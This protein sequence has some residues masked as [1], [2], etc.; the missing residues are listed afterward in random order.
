MARPTDRESF[1]QYCLRKLGHPVIRINVDAEQIEDSIDDALDLFFEYH[2][3]GQVEQYLVHQ[4]TQEQIDSGIITLDDSVY[5]VNE[6]R[7]I[8]SSTSGISNPN[9]MQMQAFFSDIVSKLAGQSIANGVSSYYLTMARFSELNRAFKV[10]TVSQFNLARNQV[11]IFS[12]LNAK[13]GDVIVMHCG[14]R[15]NPT[16]FPKVWNNKWMKDY[17][18]QLIRLQWYTNLSKYSNVQMIGGVTIDAQGQITDANEK[19]TQLQEKLR[20]DYEMPPFFFMG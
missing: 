5:A 7:V 19:I 3:D 10:F 13:A 20:S 15:T 1:K 2:F 12:S 4:L 6:V 17:T 18:T 14:L 9:D 11:H 16:E 8:Q